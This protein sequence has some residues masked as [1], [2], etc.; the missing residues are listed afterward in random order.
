MYATLILENYRSNFKCTIFDGE[1]LLACRHF[2][3]RE[4]E[5]E[6]ERERERETSGIKIILERLSNFL[7]QVSLFPRGGNRLHVFPRRGTDFRA[8]LKIPTSPFEAN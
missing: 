4:R 1:S 2:P 7:R 8:T 5:E 6:R 3:K